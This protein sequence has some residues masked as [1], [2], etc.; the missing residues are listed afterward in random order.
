MNKVHFT[1]H[2]NAHISRQELLDYCLS[3]ARNGKSWWK[4]VLTLA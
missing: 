2:I 3:S 1:L 4:L